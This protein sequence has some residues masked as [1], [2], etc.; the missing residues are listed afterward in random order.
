M[1]RTIILAF[2]TL[3]ITTAVLLAPGT[4]GAH[5][6]VPCGIYDDAAR[7]A[8]MQEDAT[9][10]RKAAAAIIELQAVDTAQAFNQATRWTAEKE[11]SASHI[12]EVVASYFLTQ[13]VKI[14]P[15]NSPEYNTYMDQLQAFHSVMVAAMKCKQGVDPARADTLDVAI[16]RVATWY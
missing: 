11:R 9:T 12:Q 2:S 3:C 1:N 8:S 10:I 14:T 6:Q 15:A 7:I 4:A 5:C 16:T 13:R